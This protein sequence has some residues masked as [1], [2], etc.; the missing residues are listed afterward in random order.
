[1][2]G[3]DVIYTGVKDPYAAAVPVPAPAPIPIYEPE[4]YVRFDVGAAWLSDGTID[5]DGSALEMRDPEKVET[6]EFGSIGAGRYIT[7]SIRVELQVDL[8][9]KGD[10]SYSNSSVYTSTRQASGPTYDVVDPISGVTTIYNTIDTKFYDVTRTEDVEYE[11]DL[12]LINVYY[13]FRNSTRFT[14][15]VGAGVGVSYR[16]LTR[17]AQETA[18]CT[19]TDNSDPSVNILYPTPYCANS[20]DLPN[21]YETTS[22]QSKNRWDVVASLSAGVAFQVTDSIIW[23]TGYRYLWQNGG[24]SLTTNSVAG[25]STVEV[26]DIGQHQLRTGIRFN[27]N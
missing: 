13:D 12:G 15:Y 18:V 8:A 25:T 21:E 4:Y 7:P 17:K 1:L 9:T 16:T 23:D 5:E 11:Q 10:I 24:L 14:P 19:D 2:A 26:K 20:P 27:L 3:G 6:F 22:E